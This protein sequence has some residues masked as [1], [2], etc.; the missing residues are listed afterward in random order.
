[1]P[2]K[3][4]HGIFIAMTLITCQFITCGIDSQ[5]AAKRRMV[6]SIPPFLKGGVRGELGIDQTEHIQ[7]IHY[8]F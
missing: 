5:M 1:M 2:V 3:K 4:G 8:D 6:W 7:D